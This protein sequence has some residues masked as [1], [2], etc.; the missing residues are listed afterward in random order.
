[1]PST[2]SRD[3]EDFLAGAPTTSDDVAALERLR[4]H[5]RLDSR[6]YL[7]FLLAFAPRHPPSR[8]VPP[9]SEPFRL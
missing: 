2:S 5:D 8:E 6:Q 3:L 1:M 7:E 4:Q 9:R